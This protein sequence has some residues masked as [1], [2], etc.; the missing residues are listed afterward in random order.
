MVNDLG[1]IIANKKAYLF[2]P[3]KKYYVSFISPL[4]ALPISA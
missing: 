4:W 1:E 2:N 3:I